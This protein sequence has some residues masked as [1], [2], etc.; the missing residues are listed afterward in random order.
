MKKIVINKSFGGFSLSQKAID[1][2]L[3]LS[4]KNHINDYD[5]KRD[6]PYLI[7]IVE[8]LGKKVNNRFS[9][10][11]IVEIPDDIEWDICEYDGQEWVAEKHRVWS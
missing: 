1:R 11:K 4:G 3:Q 2:Y 5:V 9:E 8:E 6:D 7:R 10:L